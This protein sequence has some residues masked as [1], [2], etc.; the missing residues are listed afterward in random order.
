MALCEYDKKY[1][2]LDSYK[3]GI[4]IVD[5]ES[6][7]KVAVCV[8]RA[9]EENLIYNLYADRRTGGGTLYRKMFKLKDGQVLLETCYIADIR[10]QIC[11]HVIRRFRIIDYAL[12]GEYL[13]LYCVDNSILIFKVTSD[14]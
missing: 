13:F 4:Y 1:I 3:D 9:K 2:L 12:S 5:M 6:K 8:P 10:E 11:E 14:E 7:Q